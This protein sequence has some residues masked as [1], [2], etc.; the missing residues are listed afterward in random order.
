MIAR[1]PTVLFVDD[2]TELLSQYRLLAG[3][4]HRLRLAG[5]APSAAEALRTCAISRPNVVVADV[6]MPG[7][8][9]LDL[10][11]ALLRGQP[12]RSPKIV[13]LTAFACD[14]YLVEAVGAGARG[15]LPK[16]C[17]W[18]QLEDAVVAVDEGR[19]ALPPAL[20]ARLV[21]LLLPGE[22]DLGGLS[23]REVEVLRLVGSGASPKE[24][25]SKLY[26]AEGTART[27]IERL[28]RKL[29]ANSRTQLALAAR[30]SGLWL[31]P[32]N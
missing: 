1:A 20:S 29:G 25:A 7:T 3:A 22:L 24:V 12:G 19:L 9:G 8:N 30:A 17:S 27:H 4:S 16:S 31:H 10:T 13:V 26:I 23:P 15:F 6:R 2:D 32:D 21:E 18:P 14:E 11:R 5:A 28:R